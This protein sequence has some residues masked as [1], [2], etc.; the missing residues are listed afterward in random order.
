MPAGE[1]TDGGW[2]QPFTAGLLV[3]A[4]LAQQRLGGS[5]VL[6]APRPRAKPCPWGWWGGMQ[7]ALRTTGPRVSSRRRF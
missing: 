6:A 5:L 1:R 7:V 3:C 4:R 2:A